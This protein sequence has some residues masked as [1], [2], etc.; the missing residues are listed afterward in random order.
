ME[1][2]VRVV[3]MQV[4]KLREEAKRIEARMR[5]LG[6]DRERTAAAR[7]VGIARS[8]AKRQLLRSIEEQAR[9]QVRVPPFAAKV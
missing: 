5:A 8:P 7:N 4:L 6:L 1:H 9:R 3:T 2:E